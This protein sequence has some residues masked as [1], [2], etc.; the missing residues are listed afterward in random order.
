M[1]N[2]L[3]E[4]LQLN[5]DY[6][7]CGIRPIPLTCLSKYPLNITIRNILAYKSNIVQYMPLNKYIL[8]TMYGFKSYITIMSRPTLLL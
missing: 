6:D 8:M 4:I 7:A 5:N 3:Y 1:Y 2:A